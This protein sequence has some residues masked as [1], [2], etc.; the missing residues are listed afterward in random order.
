MAFITFYSAKLASMCDGAI[1]VLEKKIETKLNGDENRE[2]ATA[3]FKDLSVITKIKSETE[4]KSLV[5]ISH[6]EWF[7][8]LQ[9]KPE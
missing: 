7:V 5:T 1:G 2:S 6:D 3:E 4:T 9:Q 8:L